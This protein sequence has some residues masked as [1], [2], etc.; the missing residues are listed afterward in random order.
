MMPSK[1]TRT[2]GGTSPANRATY[3]RRRPVRLAE[4][5]VKSAGLVV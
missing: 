1:I 3:A 5:R 2:N 4:L